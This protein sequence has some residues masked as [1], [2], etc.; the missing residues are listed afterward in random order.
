M[1]LN[2][3]QIIFPTLYIQSSGTVYFYKRHRYI[4]ANVIICFVMPMHVFIKHYKIKVLE[5]GTECSP[6]TQLYRPWNPNVW[7]FRQ[8]FCAV[9]SD[10][11]LS[12]DQSLWWSHNNHSQA[13]YTNQWTAIESIGCES[14]TVKHTKN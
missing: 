6:L 8:W 3:L 1:C 14:Y 10:Q 4:L 13:V 5:N 11:W 12:L 9:W 2:W 7:V